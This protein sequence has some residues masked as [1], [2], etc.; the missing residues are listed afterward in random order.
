[1]A[2]K[3]GIFHSYGWKV[4]MKY[5]YGIGASV[6]IIGAL[7]KI[8]HLP[9]A[10]EMLIV[11]L[12]TEAVIFFFSAFEPLPEEEVHW[13]WKRVF[14]QLDPDSNVPPPDVLG[15]G[16]AGNLGSV[17]GGANNALKNIKPDLFEGIA[18]GLKGL[19]SNV[20]KLSEV[21]D[22]TIATNEFS[23]KLKQASS[24]VEA[25]SSGFAPTIEAMKSFGNS[26]N[27]VKG[28]QESVTA[29]TKNLQALNGVYEAELK[30]TKSHLSA[31]TAFT[32]SMST[33]INNLADASK[34]S[35]ALKVE[36]VALTKNMRALNNVYG[37]MLG[38]MATA[39]Q[40]NK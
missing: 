10:N 9:G 8:L 12:G 2:K 11:G 19:K 25:M 40:A 35:D 33:V 23:D 3:G 21:A 22:V 24:K 31:V 28:Y 15:D 7:F 20:S 6:V 39:S 4:G 29:I 1:M 27:D 34:E 38:A 14:P 18:E 32:K 26:I 5:L 13:D 17:L 36:M 37:T 30:E 16:G